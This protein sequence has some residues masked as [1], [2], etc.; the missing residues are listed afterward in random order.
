MSHLGL[1]YRV[2]TN[3]NLHVGGIVLGDHVK[4]G[5][6]RKIHRR[7]FCATSIRA[8]TLDMMDQTAEDKTHQDVDRQ[9]TRRERGRYREAN[10]SPRQRSIAIS[11]A[12]S[13]LLR[14]Q[15]LDAGIPLDSAGY[16][17]LDKVVSKMPRRWGGNTTSPQY[18]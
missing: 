8:T 4:K 17:K 18:T 5:Y 10:L 12:L 7:Q 1:G 2:I 16:A 14:H 6:I 11:K 9:Q 15:A 3:I 13:R